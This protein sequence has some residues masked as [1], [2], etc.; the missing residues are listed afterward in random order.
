MISFTNM[1]EPEPNNLNCH[2]IYIDLFRWHLLNDRWHIM[3]YILQKMCVLRSDNDNGGYRENV[4]ERDGDNEMKVV[5]K[6]KVRVIVL[7]IVIVTAWKYLLI[8]NK[9]YELDPVQ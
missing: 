6:V 2:T 4:C 7:A 5:V 3:K 8:I 9:N 1:K